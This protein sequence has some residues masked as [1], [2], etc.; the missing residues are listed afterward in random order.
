MTL[1]TI[2]RIDSLQLFTESHDANSVL[3][4]AD[5]RTWFDLAILENENDQH[6][7]V[8]QEIELVWTSHRNRSQT[9]EFGWVGLLHSDQENV[10]TEHI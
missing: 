2:R 5:N 3:T 10:L 1:E 6:A 4:T 8:K 7:R 9:T